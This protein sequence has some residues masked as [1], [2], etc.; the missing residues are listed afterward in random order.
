MNERKYKDEPCFIKN[1]KH[2]TSDDNTC[3]NKNRSKRLEESLK[4]RLY[5]PFNHSAHVSDPS[6]VFL[7]F[8]HLRY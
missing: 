8:T 3:W 5:C 7:V 6:D 4:T 2:K 1:C